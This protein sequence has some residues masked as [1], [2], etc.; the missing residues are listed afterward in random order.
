MREVR[1]WCQAPAVGSS[2]DTG[3]RCSAVDVAF[4]LLRPVPGVQTPME[5]P[6]AAQGAPRC[7]W[8]GS[9]TRSPW[10]QPRISAAAAWQAD[11][12]PLSRPPRATRPTGR[13]PPASF[14]T[15]L[16]SANYP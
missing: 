4:A 1:F 5:G 9:L 3:D 11:R 6:S 13:V 10:S 8:P 7:P 12:L 16:M 2:Q 15:T 14:C